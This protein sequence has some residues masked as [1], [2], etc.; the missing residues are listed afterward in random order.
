MLSAEQ[1]PVEFWGSI[2]SVGSLGGVIG[3]N[4]AHELI[5]RRNSGLKLLGYINLIS[6][7]FSHW[8]IEHVYGH[9]KNV[10]T[11]SDPATA[12]KNESVYFFWIRNYFMGLWDAIQIDRLRPFCRN[13]VLI[14]G[15][16]QVAIACALFV[17]WG[18]IFFMYWIGV[19]VIAWLLL[20]TVDYIEHYGLQ[21]EERSPGVYGPVKAIHSWDSASAMTNWALFNLA[22]HAH[23]HFSA[24]VPYES[25]KIKGESSK[26]PFGYSS[27][28]IL[29]LVPPLFFKMMNPL[30]D[31]R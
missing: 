14:L 2:F 28:I 27:M 26:L 21:R 24:S 11:Y 8:G 15:A 31:K 17:F 30:L 9:H 22:H 12:R 25:L 13:R 16:I 18:P 20:M 7:N 10:A 19:S 6:V 4:V 29:A 5:H 23:H 3:I 1:S